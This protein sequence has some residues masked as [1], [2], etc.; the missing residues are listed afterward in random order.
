MISGS[1]MVSTY[2]SS[3]NGTALL[4]VY[5]FRCSEW[6]SITYVFFLLLQ[7]DRYSELA[8]RAGKS[9]D[10]MRWPDDPPR[11]QDSGISEAGEELRSEGFT[12]N[13]AHDGSDESEDDEF[14]YNCGYEIT[15]SESE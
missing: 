2:R 7:Y 15:E 11:D 10:D 8:R 5:R 12:S 13:A 9:E 14:F 3:N 6:P 1:W 4:T